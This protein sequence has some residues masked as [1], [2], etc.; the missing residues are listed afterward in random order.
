MAKD[1]YAQW[2]N[3]NKC[4]QTG[5]DVLT[6][7]ETI[8]PC[9]PAEGLV[10]AVH[11]IDYLIGDLNSIP[12]DSWIQFTIATKP[13]L[14]LAD[15]VPGSPYLVAWAEVGGER[16]GTGGSAT[17]KIQD[18]INYPVP[19]LVAHPKLYLYAASANSGV[20]QTVRARILFTFVKVSAEE[21]FEALTAFGL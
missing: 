21:F 7:E 8:T 14:S 3:M 9:S 15:L 10:M 6:D 5:N 11:A 4:T 16:T 17:Y 19:F 13:D 1:K 2:M 20:A 18:Q 12:V